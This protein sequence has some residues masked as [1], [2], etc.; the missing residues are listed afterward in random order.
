MERR[1]QSFVPEIQ[2]E[3]HAVR[4]LDEHQRE[5][6]LDVR[7]I[8]FYVARLQPLDQRSQALA[9]ECNVIYRA[10]RV[11]FSRHDPK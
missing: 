9:I 4:I 3:H 2:F 10:R 7:D 11:R 5:A 8:E 6:G 1:A